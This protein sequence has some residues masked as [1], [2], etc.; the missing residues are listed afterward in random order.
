[1]K[2]VRFS[3]LCTVAV[4]TGEVVAAL[5][6]AEL[7]DHLA[8]FRPQAADLPLRRRGEQEIPR[9]PGP[10]QVT[11]KPARASD[12]PAI[13]IAAVESAAG[14]QPLGQLPETHPRLVEEQLHSPGRSV[15]V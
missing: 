3:V 10:L 11:P 8:Q 12:K 4:A 9:L 1:S 15:A 14:W 7:I 2:L 13:G 6:R 5:G